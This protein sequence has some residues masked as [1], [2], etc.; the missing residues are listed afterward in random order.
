MDAVVNRPLRILHVQT[1]TGLSGGIAGYVSMLAKAPCL[2]GCLQW[3]VVPGA[4]DDPQRVH[5]LY[6][7]APTVALPPSYGRTGLLRYARALGEV[8]RR[9]RIDVVHAHAMRAALPAALAARQTGVQLVYTNHGLRYR[10]KTGLATRAIF[11]ALECFVARSAAAVVAIRPFDAAVLRR[12]RLVDEARLHTIET[13]IDVE[14]AEAP[15]RSTVRPPCLLGVGSL[16]DVKRVDRFL[17]WIAALVARG[18]AIEAVWAGDGP[19]RATFEDEARRRELPV[20]FT[21][22]QD[23]A[24]LARLYGDASLLLLTSEFEVFPLAVLEASANGVPTVSGRF[25][26]IA[27]IVEAGQTGLLVD[28]DDPTG[29][30]AAIADLLADEPRRSRLAA[31]ARRRYEA[32]FAG[33]GQ[34]ARRYADLYRAI[35]DPEQTPR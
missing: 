11:R 24:G 27:D 4:A 19:L 28:A 6:G 9:E 34:M 14:I 2:A 7:E 22:H 5:A 30:A 8:V 13:R 17:D 10:Q 1:D 15:P 23:R 29:T 32:R 21:G 20:R 12:E 35:L 18:T 25:D 3:I 16:I 33:S 26:G 31:A